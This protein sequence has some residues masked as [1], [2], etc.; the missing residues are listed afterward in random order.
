MHLS[1]LIIYNVDCLIILLNVN[2]LLIIHLCCP[3][4]LLAGSY[5][6][7]YINCRSYGY[8]LTVEP[9]VPS[10]VRCYTYYNSWEMLPGSL[11]MCENVTII[12]WIMALMH[13]SPKPYKSRYTTAILSFLNRARVR[14]RNVTID[15][16]V[17]L[18]VLRAVGEL[19]E[20]AEVYF[21]C[22]KQ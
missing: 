9:W 10:P 15:T 13:K 20:N 2:W 11:H 14:M 5:M 6:N 1:I 18:F 7:Y 4:S 16:L 17:V 19:A 22:G 3:S 8:S 21:L 12:E